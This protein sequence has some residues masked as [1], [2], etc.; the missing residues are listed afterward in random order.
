MKTFHAAHWAP[1]P[2]RRTTFSFDLQAARDRAVSATGTVAGLVAPA[3][4]WGQGAQDA[5][6][7]AG[8]QAAQILKLWNLTL[9]VC[10]AVFAMVLAAMVVALVRGRRKRAGTQAAERRAGRW[11]SGAAVLSAVLLAGLL[12]AD[13]MTDRALSRLPESDALHITMTGQQWWWESRYAPGSEG[14]AFATAGELHVPVGRTVVVTLLSADVIHT[15][16]VPNLHGKKDM[17]PGRPTTI[18]LRADKAGRFRGQCAE[19]CGTEHALMA[20]GV[21]ADPPEDYLRWRMAQQAPA[22]VPTSAQAVRG[23]SIFMN[24]ACA[25]CHA[26]RG[27]DAAGTIGPDLTHLASRPTIAAGSAPNTT[28]TLERWVRNPGVVKPGAAMPASALSS[29]DLA[30]LV[31]YLRGLS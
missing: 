31:S 20:F 15:F 24:S 19:F 30:D 22:T 29:E 25:G 6:R 10:C 17:L 7:P 23:Q 3:L 13:V 2:D 16:W 14:P 28:E 18:T 26:V 4:A 8:P 21:V 5:L 1:R 27:T 11:V 12:A 9:I